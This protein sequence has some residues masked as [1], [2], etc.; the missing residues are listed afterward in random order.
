MVMGDIGPGF[1]QATGHK[2]A[3]VTDRRSASS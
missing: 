2:I 1:E 3:L